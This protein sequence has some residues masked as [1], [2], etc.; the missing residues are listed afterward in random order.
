M[1]TIWKY[2]LS[3]AAYQTVEIPQG[4]QLLA[5]QTLAGDLCLWALVDPKNVLEKREIEIFGTGHCIG[6]RNRNYIGTAQIQ[7]A[8]LVLHVFEILKNEDN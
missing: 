7:S 5:T 2:K 8:P 3:I 4:A 6:E 1:K